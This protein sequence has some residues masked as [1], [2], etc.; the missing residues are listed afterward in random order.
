MP[1]PFAKA[2]EKLRAAE[3]RPTRQRVALAK[4]LLDGENRHV[5][6]EQLHN[7]AMAAGID[8][9]VATIYNTLNQFTASGLLREVTVENGRSYFD[10]NTTNHHHFFDVDSGTLTDIPNG[11]ISI[12][13]L[14]PLPKGTRME[15]VELVIKV[16]KS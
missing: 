3:L 11:D 13:A 14:P 8:V 6:A 10:T 15:S 4:L 7:E 16:T 2:V 12:G 1:R 5:T 9:S